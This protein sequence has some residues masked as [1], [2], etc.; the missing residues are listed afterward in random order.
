MGAAQ[1]VHII[2]GIDSPPATAVLRN[3]LAPN[4]RANPS[5]GR[6]ACTPDPIRRPRT[7]ACQIALKYA[8]VYDHAA[9]HPTRGGAAAFPLMIDTPMVCCAAATTARWKYG[10]HFT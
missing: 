8:V 1:H 3:P 6:R 2:D 10:P 9:C 4:T 7:M 5:R